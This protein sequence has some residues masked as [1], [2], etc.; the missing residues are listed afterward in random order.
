[1]ESSSPWIKHF[2]D[3]ASDLVPHKKKYYT[4]Q[5][6]TGNGDVQLV[7]PTQAEV[8]RAKMDIKRKLQKAST[9]KPKRLRSSPQSGS[10]QKKK[11]KKKQKGANSKK[12]TKSKKSK[13]KYSSNKKS[14]TKKKSK[15]K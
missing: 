15:K 5:T 6:Q 8:E 1:M 13:S 3:M 7:T 12:S 11:K 9:Y 2:T 4:V 14:S 10:G